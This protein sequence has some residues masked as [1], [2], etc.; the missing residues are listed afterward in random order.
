MYKPAILGCQSNTPEIPRECKR[1]KECLLKHAPLTRI[2]SS[3]EMYQARKAKG[4]L[5]FPPSTSM[6]YSGER[7]GSIQFWR[8]RGWG[9]EKG[10]YVRDASMAEFGSRNE[11]AAVSVI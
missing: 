10:I 6:W 5:C 11:L 9:A 1:M 7:F 8:I 2:W 4:V 3:H